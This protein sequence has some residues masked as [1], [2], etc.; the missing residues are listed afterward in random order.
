[1]EIDPA[2]RRV[3]I[4]GSE[5]ANRVAGGPCVIGAGFIDGHAF[6]P[7]LA[8]ESAA[9][10]DGEEDLVLRAGGGELE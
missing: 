10:G 7:G 3:T 2:G 8:L 9:V 6:E 4:G 5:G 1:V